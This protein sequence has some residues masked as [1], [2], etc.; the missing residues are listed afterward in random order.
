MGSALPVV[1]VVFGGF[2]R[3]PEVTFLYVVGTGEGLFIGAKAAADV[4]SITLAPL[5]PFAS[6][7]T[8]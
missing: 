4:A 6:V 1:L 5:A 7:A 2:P 8:S 3:R